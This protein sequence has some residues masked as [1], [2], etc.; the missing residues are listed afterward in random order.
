[1]TATLGGQQASARKHLLSKLS[2]VAPCYNE[3]DVLPVFYEALCAVLEEM[4]DLFCELVFIDDGSTDLTLQVLTALAA[5]DER[6][7][8]Y[9][10]SRNFGHQV[11]LTAGLDVADGDAV[12]LMDSDLQH[13]PAL[14]PQ[15]VDLWRNGVDVVSTVRA[16]TAGVSWMKEGSSRLFYRLINCLSD[17]RITPG[18]ADFVLLSRRACAALRQMPERH[19]FL[20]GMVSWIGFERAW[21]PF[22]APARAAGASK[23]TVVRMVAMAM[24]AVLS[25]S[26]TSVRFVSRLGMCM[27][28]LAALYLVTEVVQYL[29]YRDAVAGWTSLIGL[30]FLL[31][32]LQIL[33]VGVIGEYVAR[34][35]EESKRR[36]LYFFKRTPAAPKCDR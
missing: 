36:P 3:Q 21:V 31:G 14:L 32:G 23:Y 35:F 15:M 30:I 12:V 8:V 24:D 34:V 18:A 27:V 33:A 1:M 19:R 11:A 25:F 28:L 7:R 29:R 5:K 16:K 2:I 9:S 17:T 22:T 20:R 4:P 13:P 6:V 10:L 26:S